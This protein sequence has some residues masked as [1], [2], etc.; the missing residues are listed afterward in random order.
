M[1]SANRLIIDG[2]G[3][4]QLEQVKRTGSSCHRVFIADLMLQG[5]SPLA[6]TGTLTV[7]TMGLIYEWTH[8]L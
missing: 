5:K 8:Y 7:Y 3:V 6:L 1:P 2:S 4:L